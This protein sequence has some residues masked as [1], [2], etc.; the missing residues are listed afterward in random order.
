MTRNTQLKARPTILIVDD[1]RPTRHLLA[2]LLRAASFSVAM[3]Q[4]GASA[5]R[6]VRVSTFDLIHLDIWM[7]R[8][9][10]LELLAR[11]R[12]ILFD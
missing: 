7:P 10:G 6:H 9:T 11:L 2:G 4:D 5:L 1:D 12:A 8:M 3:A